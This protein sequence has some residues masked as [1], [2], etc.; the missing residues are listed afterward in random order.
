MQSDV[1]TFIGKYI[2]SVGELEIL[3]LLH[4][5]PETYWAADAI[6]NQLG[7]SVEPVSKSVHD[8][9]R[10]KLLVQGTSGAVFRFNPIEKRHAEIVDELALL[11]RDQRIQVINAIYDASMV[12]LR[13]FS[14]AFKIGGDKS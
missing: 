3:L 4:R 14:D 12:R 7:I 1:A 2:R 6:A 8:L 5:S 11:Y 13:S 10:G 9:A